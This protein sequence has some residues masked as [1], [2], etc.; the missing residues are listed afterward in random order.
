MTSLEEFRREAY[1]ILKEKIPS[2][3]KSWCDIHGGAGFGL[4]YRKNRIALRELTL[5]PRF[6]SAGESADTSVEIFGRKFSIPVFPA[7]FG[8]RVQSIRRDIFEQ[9]A[10]ACDEM[11][12]PF[13]LG[14]PMDIS[15]VR[16]LSE[17]YSN[18]IWFI[19]PM[20]DENKM[21]ELF[22]AANSIETLA[23]GMDIDSVCGICEG[24]TVLFETEFSPLK[25]EMI[26]NMIEEAVSP[27]ILKGI[28]SEEDLKIAV[29]LGADA[30]VVSNH[31]GTILDSI[32]AS[33]EALPRLDHPLK[34]VDGGFRSG[35]DVLKALALGARAVLIGRPILWGAT[36]R[37]KEGVVEVLRIFEREL[38]RAMKLTG[39]SRI[40]EIDE[41]ILWK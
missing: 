41:E 4:T 5:K 36:V 21:R 22:N 1:R 27:F 39:V 12:V 40:E 32:P 25:A 34:M 33:I 14:Y 15:Y 20:R 24:S 29:E 35:V 6:L 26:G 38:K 7:P 11:N 17:S 23:I 10:E 18:L 30:I 9:I 13:T 3:A 16:E 31:G 37:G 28:L 2:M 19:K 8:M